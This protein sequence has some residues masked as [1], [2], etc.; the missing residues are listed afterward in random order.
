MRES[1]IAL[2]KNLYVLLGVRQDQESYCTL[3]S[4]MDGGVI[5][6]V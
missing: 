6:E 4:T 5:L 1:E 2:F 3:V